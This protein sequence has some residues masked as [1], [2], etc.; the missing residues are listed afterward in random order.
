MSS[1]VAVFV[2]TAWSWEFL[3][4]FSLGLW[5]SHHLSALAWSRLSSM[6][7]LCCYVGQKEGETS[8]QIKVKV[9]RCY[10]S[11]RSRLSSCSVWIWLCSLMFC[12]G[13][14]CPIPWPP[15]AL[16]FAGPGVLHTLWSKNSESGGEFWVFVTHGMEWLWGW[17][18]NPWI[19]PAVISIIEAHNS[20]MVFFL[21]SCMFY[22]TAVSPNLFVRLEMI[23]NE[24]SNTEF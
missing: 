12:C 22:R 14:R 7:I 15:P 11:T 17:Q 24:E 3:P 6:Q 4:P 13:F 1:C 19:L 16:L 8:S 10:C 2:S 21:D 18:R 5:T 9:M 20:A 23:I